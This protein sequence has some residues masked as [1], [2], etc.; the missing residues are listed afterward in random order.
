MT[1]EATAHDH[2]NCELCDLLQSERAAVSAYAVSLE[3]AARL[4]LPILESMDTLRHFDPA[5]PA[6]DALR[7]ALAKNPARS[8]S[9]SG[10]DTRGA[11]S[12]SET[13]GHEGSNPSERGRDNGPLTEHHRATLER[14][15]G[16]HEEQAALWRAEDAVNMDPE[17][18]A[19]LH[20]GYASVARAALAKKPNHPGTT[21][22][23]RLWHALMAAGVC[24]HDFADGPFTPI[25][26][27]SKR[28]WFHETDD[29]ENNTLA[30]TMEAYLRQFPVH[31]RRGTCEERPSNPDA[32]CKA[33]EDAL[34]SYRC[35]YTRLDD[36][37]GADGGLPLVDMLTP[38][39]DSTV[40]YG[41]YELSALA[42]HL[43]DELPPFRV[44]STERHD[45]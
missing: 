41:E 23:G 15:A 26:S 34:R 1:H 4:A 40:K 31:D 42:E 6:L 5:F 28:I 32:C 12:V 21:D 33:I 14:I 36:P 25:W 43:F 16:Y 20:D 8:P 30:A 13:R 10:E 2:G 37:E 11:E 35:R 9:P 27:G 22:E 45:D 24:H 7:A 18:M 38:P 17:G 3:A 29:T 39:A 44:P 19:L